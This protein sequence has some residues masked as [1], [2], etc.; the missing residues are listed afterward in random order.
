M[1]GG[2]GEEEG[3]RGVNWSL[4]VLKINFTKNKQKE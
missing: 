3:R 4:T 2:G 1:K